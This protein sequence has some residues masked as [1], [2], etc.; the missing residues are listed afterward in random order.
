[1]SNVPRHQANESQVSSPHISVLRN[2]TASGEDLTPCISRRQ[3][4]FGLSKIELQL[5]HLGTSQLRYHFRAASRKIG[6]PPM[7]LSETGKE[8]VLHEPQ[9]E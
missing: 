2:M 5:T 6:T 1:M 4:V 7:R 3:V 8:R 9:C